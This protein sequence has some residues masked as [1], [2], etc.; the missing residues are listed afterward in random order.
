MERNDMELFAP[1]PY[2]KKE[3][4]VMEDLQSVIGL[5]IYF[6]FLLLLGVGF[7]R[8]LRLV[9]RLFKQV[10]QKFGKGHVN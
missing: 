7:S 10:F 4:G 6:L 9:I 3:M 5:V 2:K 1:L 8:L